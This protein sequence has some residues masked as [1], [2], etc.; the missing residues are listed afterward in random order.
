[1][2]DSRPGSVALLPALPSG[3]KEGRVT[4]LRARGGLTVDIEWKNGVVKT[5]RLL[6]DKPQDVRVSVRGTAGERTMH[7]AAGAATTLQF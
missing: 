3:W 2:I 7:L 4:G 5:A 6:A 1:L